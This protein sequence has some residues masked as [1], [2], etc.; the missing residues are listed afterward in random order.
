MINYLIG[1]GAA[2]IVIL[3]AKNFIKNARSGE[4]KCSSGCN[5]CSS[6]NQCNHK[7]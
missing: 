1:I 3:T 6:G 2:L 7:Q 4:T 5:G